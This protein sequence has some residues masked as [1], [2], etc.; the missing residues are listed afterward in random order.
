MSRKKRRRRSQEADPQ[1]TTEPRPLTE[2]ARSRLLQ[3]YQHMEGRSVVVGW[4]SLGITV[5]ASSPD[6]MV[7]KTDAML[8]ERAKRLRPS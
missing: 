6:E 7:A 1:T 4:A 3:R 5:E 8:I 2:A